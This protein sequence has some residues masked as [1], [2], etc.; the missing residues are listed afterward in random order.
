MSNAF[1]KTMSFFSKKRY[2][3]NEKRFVKSRQ[4]ENHKINKNNNN[5]ICFFSFVFSNDIIDWFNINLSNLLNSNDF[6]DIVLKN[7]KKI[8][9][10]M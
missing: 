1:S 9:N 7:V 2:Q 10:D 4:I 8:L 5:Y 6:G 3:N